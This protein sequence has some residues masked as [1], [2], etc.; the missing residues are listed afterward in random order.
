M[1]T[2]VS[3]FIKNVEIVLDAEIFDD[4]GDIVEFEDG[5]SILEDYN[6]IVGINAHNTTKFATL[7][8]EQY[9]YDWDMFDTENESVVVFHGSFSFE[10]KS[11]KSFEYWRSNDELFNLLDWINPED[12][13]II[14]A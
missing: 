12:V 9:S 1:T 4:N 10:D 11:A 5:E 6:V 13:K 2:Q 8:A 7:F 3:T 14:Q